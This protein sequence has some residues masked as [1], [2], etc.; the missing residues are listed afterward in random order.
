MAVLADSIVFSLSP[1]TLRLPMNR[2]SACGVGDGAV[3]WCVHGKDAKRKQR[4]E[5]G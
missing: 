5:M 3:E 4:Q 1:L 2:F